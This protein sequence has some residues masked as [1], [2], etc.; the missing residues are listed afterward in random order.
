MIHL[1]FTISFAICLF[2]NQIIA[3]NGEY[4]FINISDYYMINSSLSKEEFENFDKSVHRLGGYFSPF[5]NVTNT[6]LSY[7]LQRDT[8]PKSNVVKFNAPYFLS[9]LRD[10]RLCILGDSTSLQMALSLFV[11]LAEYETPK[12]NELFNEDIVHI[13][14]RYYGDYNA[15]I[16][17]CINLHL[18]YYELKPDN[19]RTVFIQSALCTRYCMKHGD[20][21]ELAGGAHYKPAYELNGVQN[22]ADLGEQIKRMNHT[23]WNTRRRIKKE[24]PKLKVIWRDHHH[25][26]K[27]FAS[28]KIYSDALISSNVLLPEVSWVTTFNKLIHD[29]AKAFG[30]PVLEYNK[31]SKMYAEYFRNL[32]GGPFPVKYDYL[33]YAHGGMPRTNNLLLQDTIDKLDQIAGK[34]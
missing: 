2:C 5:A 17:W 21:L 7:H 15:L 14:Y 11:D 9:K 10:K 3:I 31:L 30:D 26:A 32:K 1:S 12:K 27:I 20:Y 22:S 16:F 28:H 19:N 33:H 25:S 4:S 29:I 6:L 34:A 24:N 23:I 18:K 8:I 13:K